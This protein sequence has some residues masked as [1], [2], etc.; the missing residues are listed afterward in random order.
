M[1]VAGDNIVGLPG[2]RA[3]DDFVVRRVRSDNLYR[4]SGL[5]CLREVDDPVFRQRQGFIR[6]AEFVA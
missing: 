6:P 3:F 2:Q 5:D 4:L 1:L